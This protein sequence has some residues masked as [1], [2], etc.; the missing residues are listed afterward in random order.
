MLRLYGFRISNYFNMVKFALLEKGL[1]FEVI[2]T[3]PNQEN[4]FTAKSP[5]GKV[6]C[7]ETDQGCLSETSAIFDWLEATKPSPALLPSDP[8]AAAK[9]REIMKILE[10]Y[11]ELQGRRHY[12]EVFFGE[13]RSETALAEAKPVL[14][15]G[16]KAL[17]ALAKFDPYICGEFSYADIMAAQTFVYTAPVCQAVYGWDIIADVPGL[18]AAINGTNERPAGARVSVEQQQALKAFRESQG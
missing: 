13:K 5:M 16:L 7:I 14:E 1:E 6:P 11:I 15:K 18:Q 10:L 12:A 4:A 2:D 3:M 8:F 17:V 9:V